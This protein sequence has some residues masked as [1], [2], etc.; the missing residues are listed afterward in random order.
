MMTLQDVKNIFG[1]IAGLG[2]FLYGM[3]LLSGGLQKVAG[4]KMKSLL[5]AVTSKR[6]TAILVGALITAI[7][8]SSGA[9]TVMVVGFVN[10]G[11]MSLLQSV[12]VTM[13]A[14]IGTTA[15]AWLVSLDSLG[16]SATYIKPSFYAPIM[17]G[18]GAA[19]MMFS[20]KHK[21]QSFGEIIL[22]L[23]MLFFGLSTMSSSVSTY[24][25]SESVQNAFLTI[26][27][28]PFMGLVIGFI[29]TTI[30]QSSSAS[31]GVL[32]TLSV[33]GV[34]DAGTAVYVCLGANIG[35]TTTALMSAM[36]AS[37]D[38]KRSAVINLLL[39]IFG[40]IIFGTIIYIFFLIKPTFC[41][42]V[43]SSVAIAV[44]QTSYKAINAIV[45][46]PF[47]DKLVALSG[48]LVK[49]KKPKTPVATL[50]GGEKHDHS[51]QLD[52]RIINTP[53]LA[54]Q[55]AS[56][57]VV[58]LG[59][60][61]IENIERSLDACMYSKYDLV[62]KIYEVEQ[63]IDD[64]T[65]DLS[66][67]LVKLTNA[68]LTDKQ[69]RV[70]KDLMYTII[71]LERV[72]DHAENMADYACK[73]RD[74]KLN[75]SDQGVEDLTLMRKAVMGSLTNAVEAR[76]TG[77]LEMVRANLRFEDEV[78][79][80]EEEIREKHIERLSRGEC[81]SE[82]GVIFLNIL[83]NLERVSDHAVNIAGY[84]KDEA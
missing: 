6:G 23:G 61:C 1:F 26:G 36:G 74:T 4:D 41:E 14:N 77:N 75:F 54:I 22:A 35:S 65:A 84:V 53:S 45:F 52:E 51:M 16:E 10:A 79:T 42:Y 59:H 8:Q 38:A 47:A 13:G 25:N 72:G 2:L 78:D 28:N 37:R 34:V 32:Q 12:G 17:I 5:N 33:Y 29:V 81:K 11:L 80:L 18:I 24:M 40:T 43:M 9:T 73:L 62:D 76:A 19:I 44:F 15:T 63:R 46:Y 30:M 68:G 56:N 7:I 50:D 66:E 20:K 3:K 48:I 58:D 60:I 55:A 67:F 31:V 27:Q 82:T 64:D 49:E 83:T 21:L 71:D 69:S 70:V 39:N 57:Y